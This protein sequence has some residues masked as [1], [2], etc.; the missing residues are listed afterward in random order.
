MT[1]QTQLTPNLPNL[2]ET[3]E[4]FQDTAVV[5]GTA[6][7]YMNVQPQAYRF[8]ILNAADDRSFNLQ[9][10]VASSIVS[11]IS[12]TSG[13]SGYT[14]APVVTITPNPSDPGVGGLPPW[15][16]RPRPPSPTAS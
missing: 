1:I 9:M 4:A 7:P 11:S 8:R 13:G 5:N 3:T 16:P 2:S 15:A 6:Y 10:Y 14:T 12:V